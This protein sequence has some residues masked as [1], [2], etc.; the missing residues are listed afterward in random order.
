MAILFLAMTLTVS[1][2]SKLCRPMSDGT[3]KAMAIALGER[4]GLDV[5]P[6]DIEIVGD[7][8]FHN[9]IE[10]D[11][12]DAYHLPLSMCAEVW[13][14]CVVGVSPFG[15]TDNAAIQKTVDQFDAEYAGG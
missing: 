5:L 2:R 10:V 13:E 7:W 9:N 12:V 8:L 15:T 3:R 14:Q 1:S 4:T 6:A 11:A